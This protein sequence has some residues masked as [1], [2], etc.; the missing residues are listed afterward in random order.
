M[1]AGAKELG[2]ICLGRTARKGQPEKAFRMVQA[3]QEREDRMARTG[4]KGRVAGTGKLRYD[5][6]T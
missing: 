2:T 1:T 5:N 3:G 4:Q 6:C